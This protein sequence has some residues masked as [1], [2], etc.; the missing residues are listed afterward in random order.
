[1]IMA[2]QYY[3][4]DPLQ[5]HSEWFLVSSPDFTEG[6]GTRLNVFSAEWMPSQAVK[7]LH[8]PLL[9]SVRMHGKKVVHSI[10]LLKKQISRYYCAE[11]R[12]SAVTVL[13]T[14]EAVASF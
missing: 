2:P 11:C 3:K 4:L 6:L 7:E 5:F 9:Y 14:N 8:H 10:V 13:I 1:M 12:C